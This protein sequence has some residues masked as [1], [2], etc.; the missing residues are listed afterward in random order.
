MIS[1]FFF[2][3]SCFRVSSGEGSAGFSEPGL[4]PS[5]GF[6]SEDCWVSVDCHRRVESCDAAGRDNLVD[7]EVKDEKCNEVFCWSRG[8]CIACCE[9]ARV[10]RRSWRRNMID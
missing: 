7:L 3:I 8:A 10:E 5:E 1:L 2:S 6:E 4:E 9:S